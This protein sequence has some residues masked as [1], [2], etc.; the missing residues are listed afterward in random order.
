M[1]KLLKNRK[2]AILITIIVVI[3]ATLFGISRS[4][5]RLARDV[6]A[7]FYDGIYLEETGQP[8]R[9]INHHLGNLEQTALDA[10][11]VFAGNPGLSNESEA[12]RL[13]RRDLLD[14]RSISEKY[15]A[16]QSLHQAF[17]VFF[18]KAETVDLSER[19]KDS[20]AQ[21]RSTF[22]GATHA[23]QASEYNNRVRDFMGG[24]SIIAYLLKPFIFV[25]SPQ[26]FG[27]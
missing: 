19:D 1:M 21:F 11:F 17:S 4:L 22:T 3:L 15:V 2:I 26:A 9:S 18:N 7:L 23:I 5:N 27:T 25:T 8:Q 6:E 14:A 13:A 16:Y 12:L 10:S 24:S 20:L